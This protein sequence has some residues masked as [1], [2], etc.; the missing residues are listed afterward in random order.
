MNNKN[1]IIT[2]IQTNPELSIRDTAKTLGISKSTIQR[3]KKDLGHCPKDTVINGTVGTLNGTVG[4]L[5]GTVGTL[6]FTTNVNWDE[7][8][9]QLDIIFN[10]P[11]NNSIDEQY[12]K[13]VIAY[14]RIQ[15][16]FRKAVDK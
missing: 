5:N 6:S 9:E 4:T 11:A 2:F 13:A 7:L 8:E 14:E 10:Y 12:T 3:V 16:M 15:D 1:D